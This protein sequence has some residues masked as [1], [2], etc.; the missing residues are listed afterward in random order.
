MLV[1]VHGNVGSD[2]APSKIMW[3]GTLVEYCRQLRDEG[4][5]LSTLSTKQSKAQ[6]P[7]YK[8][9]SL[10]MNAERT[11]SPTATYEQ[12]CSSGPSQVEPDNSSGVM[13][14]SL[15][16]RS[17]HPLECGGPAPLMLQLLSRL[18]NAL[19]KRCLATALQNPRR[20]PVKL[21]SL[22]KD[23]DPIVASS[24]GPTT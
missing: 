13:P 6:S 12:Q 16:F 17:C 5:A 10:R 15:S 19:T 21:H 11:T 3:P 14:C 7:K 22:D 2:P 24:P 18:S 8:E 1:G 23:E 9:Q 4:C 20:M